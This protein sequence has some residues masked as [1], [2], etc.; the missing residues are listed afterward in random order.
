MKLSSKLPK[1]LR[2]YEYNTYATSKNYLCIDFETTALDKGSALNGANELVLWVATHASGVTGS[3]SSS[4]FKQLIKWIHDCDFIIAHNAKFELQW[5]YRLGLEPGSV[6][7]YDTMLAEKVLKGNIRTDFSLDGVASSYGLENKDEI[8]KR[9][10]HG[11]TD[12]SDISPQRLFEY[13]KQDVKLT[14]DVFQAQLPRLQK[15]KLLPVLF[16]RCLTC[17]VLADLEKNGMKLDPDLVQQEYR[18]TL[19]E[20]QTLLSELHELT[21]GINPKSRQQVAEFLYATLGFQELQDYKGNVLKTPGGDPRTGD[22]VV[23]QL[24][25]KTKEQK[26]FLDA[27]LAYVPI[28]KKLETLTKFNECCAANELLQFNYNQ[29]TVATHRLSSNGKKYK[30]QGQNISR[31]FKRL[32]HS[33]HHEWLIGDVDETQMEFRAAGFLGR[34]LQILDDVRNKVDIHRNTAAA[35]LKKPAEAITKDERTEYKPDTFAPLYGRVNGTPEQKRYGEFFKARYHSIVKCQEGWA[36]EVLANKKLVLASGLIV[37][38]PDIQ[39]KR[40]GR[41]THSTEVSNY[42]I[43]SFCGAELTPIGLIYLWYFMRGMQSFLVNTVHDSVVA[44]LHPDEVEEWYRLCREAF[45][46]FR[47]EYLKKVYKLNYDFPLGIAYS[48]ASHWGQGVDIEYERNLM[49]K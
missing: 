20:S 17:I 21:G 26:Q 39:M 32:F 33:R 14:L 10:I 6:M 16:T 37:Y 24:K 44:E 11:G 1:F 40:N 22:E 38:W 4:N 7:V 25:P 29:H 41:I 15:D 9:M 5:L 42:P 27:F 3:G 28:K 34:D 12:P 2:N 30:I 48:A 18:K 46:V 36:Y 31:G 43:Q 8:V 35:M 23:S 19:F 49:S 45:T 47:V 13:C